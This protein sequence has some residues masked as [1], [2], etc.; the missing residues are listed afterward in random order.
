MYDTAVDRQS[1]DRRDQDM[2]A[3]RIFDL[4]QVLDHWR[5]MAGTSDVSTVSIT[6]GNRHST[7][8]QIQHCQ[9]HQ[10]SPF[11][12]SLWPFEERSDRTSPFSHLFLYVHLELPMLN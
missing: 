9:C 1:W 7:H 10:G 2:G 11:P 8:L 6:E 5:H 3:G 4:L 12:A